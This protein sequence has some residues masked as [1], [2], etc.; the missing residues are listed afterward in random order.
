MIATR[1]WVIVVCGA[2]GLAHVVVAVDKPDAKSKPATTPAGSGGQFGINHAGVT[3]PAMLDALNRLHAAG[4]VEGRRGTLTFFRWTNAEPPKLAHL[5]L[6]GSQVGNEHAALA[7]SLPDLEFVSLYETNIDD[8]GVQAFAQLPKLRRLAVAPIAR[9]EKSGYSPPQ[10]SYPF[11]AERAD[12]P[13]ITAAGLR[14]FAN[15][16]TLES[17]DLLDARLSSADLALLASWPK[18][19][20][21]SLPNVI[22]TEA[23]RHLQTCSKLNHLTL[24]YREVSAE[25][26][27]YLAD[28]KSLRTL[29]LIHARLSDE[30]LQALSKLDSVEQLELEDCGLTDERLQH[31]HGSKKLTYLSLKRNEIDGPGLVHIAK[32]KL[33]TL[34]LEFNN[35]NDDGLSYLPQL[36]SLEELW[37]AYCRGI[38]DRGLRNG[39]LQTMTHLRQLNL[40]GLQQVTDASLDDLVRFQH[41]AH[42]GIRET[43]ISGD[44]VAR[45]KQA[46]PKTVVF[47]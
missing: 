43:K 6:W 30:A 7:S 4:V 37:L 31:L 16:A 18:L 35:L 5:G 14:A 38:T 40:R 12:R 8:R 33:R 41:L 22:D 26:L 27:K 10:W 47:K 28:W 24:G 20:S 13:R 45:L 19:S 15:V 21:L 39:T 9:Y 36:T 29:V 42:L 23:V 32:L 2:L 34:G 17:L 44:G 1:G 25:E 3:S 11:I 46:L